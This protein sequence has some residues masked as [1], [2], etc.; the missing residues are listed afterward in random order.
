MYLIHSRTTT[1]LIY[2][3]LKTARKKSRKNIIPTMIQGM[4]NDLLI[5]SMMQFVTVTFAR[6][7][8]SIMAKRGH[9]IKKVKS[10]H[11]LTKFW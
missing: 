6:I 10:N 11:L 1:I 9:W 4:R 3:Y 8:I 5:I 2:M 7:G